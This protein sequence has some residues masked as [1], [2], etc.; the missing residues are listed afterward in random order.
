MNNS[1]L[2]NSQPTQGHSGNNTETSMDVKSVFLNGKL[3]EEV[4]VKQPPG[5]KSSEFH[6]Y[7]C[8]PDKALYGLKQAPRAWRYLHVQVFVDDI[9]FGSRNYKL[10]KQFEKQMTNK[11]EISMMGELTYFLGFQIKQD[12]KVS[13]I[14]QEKYT[15]DLLKKYEISNSA[16]VK[17][18]MANP[19]ESH[20]IAVKRIFM[21]LKGTPTLGLWYPKCLGFYLKGYS[22]S[23]YTRCNMDKKSTLGACQLLG[24]KI[25]CWSAKKQQLVAMS[26]AKAE[27]IDAASTRL[28]YNNGQY[29]DLPQTKVVKAKLLKLGLAK[30]LVLGGK[31]FSTDKLNSTK[32]MMVFSLLTWTKIDIEEIIYTDLMTRILEAPRK[33]YVAYPRFISYALEWL[34]NID[35]AQDI[36]FGSIPS[37]LSTRKSQ[38]LSKGTFIDPKDLG[39]N[40]QLT[41]KGLPFTT[42]TDQSGASTKYHVDK[43]QSTPFE[44]PDPDQNK[45]KT[46]LEM[47]LDNQ[48]LIQTYRHFQKLMEDS[49]DELKDISDDDIFEDGEGMDDPFPLHADEES[50]P[51]PSTEQPSTKSQHAEPTSTKHQSPS[52]DKAHTE[53]SKEEK[54][55]KFDESPAPSNFESSLVRYDELT[56]AEK[57]HEACDIKE[58]NILLQGLP[59]DIYNLVNHHEEAKRIWDRAKLLIKGFEILLRER[60]SKLYDEFEMFTLVPRE[61]IHSYYLRFAQLINNMHSI[62]MTMRQIQVNTTFIN[63]LQPEWSKFVTDVKLAKDLN[64]TN[65]D[66]LYGYLR[67]HEAHADEVRLTRQRF[68]NPIALVANTYNSAPSYSIKT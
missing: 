62:R 9:I 33:K 67:Q 66:H 46:S 44:V 36:T 6:D 60:D 47:D 15:R 28:E 55:K 56:D 27:Y 34:L 7:V 22:D 26:F 19:K 21:Y 58:T 14:C 49:D 43:T 59:Q 32:K 50:Q 24:G 25:V 41:N 2:N 5:F 38:P 42:V 39:R 20:L 37:V 63:H 31:K 17:T 57:L 8:K 18:H 68:S 61:T 1:K 30:N 29:A 10:C 4:Y 65:F 51:P 13:S 52:P 35:Y 11:F 53:S 23:D 16:L 64:N 12:D 3:K 54:H 40:I 45:G 48:P